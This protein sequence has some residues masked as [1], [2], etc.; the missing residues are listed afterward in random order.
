MWVWWATWHILSPRASLTSSTPISFPLKV[1]PSPRNLWS[2]PPR[3]GEGGEGGEGGVGG[4]ATPTNYGSG[5]L[6]LLVTTVCMA[7]IYST[8]WPVLGVSMAMALSASMRAIA[9]RLDGSMQGCPVRHLYLA[10]S[11]F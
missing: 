10:Q 4:G 9:S 1:C 11:V 5:L 2:V 7:P 8:I 3:P 6:G